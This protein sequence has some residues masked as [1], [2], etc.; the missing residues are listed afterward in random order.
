MSHFHLFFFLLINRPMLEIWVV[1]HT[2]EYTKKKKKT[3][4]GITN[5]FDKIPRIKTKAKKN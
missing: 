3:T 5:S 2:K 4:V 1:R